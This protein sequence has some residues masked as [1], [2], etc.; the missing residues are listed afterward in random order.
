MQLSGLSQFLGAF[1]SIILMNVL[2]ELFHLIIKTTFVALLMRELSWYEND[3]LANLKE[4]AGKN[5]FS[6]IT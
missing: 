4:E 3:N 5:N 6:S 1:L 2:S